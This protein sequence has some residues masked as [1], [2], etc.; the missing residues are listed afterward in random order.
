MSEIVILYTRFLSK[1]K[2][3][4]IYFALLS[5]VLSIGLPGLL[6]VDPNWVPIGSI[7][8]IGE[9]GYSYLQDT[10]S[11]PYKVS[12]N[13]LTDTELNNSDALV[14][15]TPS[16]DLTRDEVN[17]LHDRAIKNYPTIIIGPNFKSNARLKLL[18]Q[19]L[20]GE[21]GDRIFDSRNNGGY[22]AAPKVVTT[23][24]T[25][26]TSIV[27]N[28]ISYFWDDNETESLIHTY[29]SAFLSKCEN[30]NDEY[31]IAIKAYNTIILTDS[32]MLRNNF[33]KYH[34]ENL[35]VMK[36]LIN[37]LDGSI[38]S[39]NIN[40]NNLK[41]VPLNHKGLEILIYHFFNTRFT[42]SLLIFL[43]VILPLLLSFQ[44]NFFSQNTRRSRNAYRRKIVER[45]ELLHIGTQVVTPL[46][47]EEKIMIRSGIDARVYGSHYLR[48]E[49]QDLSYYIRT[50]KLDKYLPISLLD[51]IEFIIKNKVEENFVWE[52]IR[53]T[54]SYIDKISEVARIGKD[55]SEILFK[56]NRRYEEE[57]ATNKTGGYEIW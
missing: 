57:S 52:V 49:V 45:L 47:L 40:E 6:N 7:D 19:Y 28:A 54:N 29:N 8:D 44:S 17:Y 26:F 11:I 46:S 24:G 4:Y 34:P 25:E 2:L 55:P 14:L 23:N 31:S 9:N 37:E 30:C 43:A 18:I 22:S 16:V 48:K 27:P 33:T 15:F 42:I 32:W 13:E 39:L 35:N 56:K 36:Y 20:G 50:E 41:W 21:I 51:Y 12:Y 1:I 53:V 10:F 38:S 5:I 3:R